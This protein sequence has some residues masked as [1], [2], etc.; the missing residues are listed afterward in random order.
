MLMTVLK[1]ELATK[2]SKALIRLFKRL[3]DHVIE[4]QGLIGRREFLLL[5]MQVSRDEREID[6]LRTRLWEVEDDMSRV[7]EQL[8]DLVTKSEMAPVAIDFGNP[9]IRRDYLVMN[10]DPV[11]GAL[12]YGDIYGWAAESIIVVDN[13]IGLKTLVL[14]KSAQPGVSITVISDNMGR[15][16]HRIEYEDFKR[17]YPDIDVEFRQTQGIV[18]DRYIALDY[19]TD[20]ERVFHCG[21]SSKDAGKKATT[22][23]EAEKPSIYHPLFDQLLAN[24]RLVLE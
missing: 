7:V 20:F 1:G 8:G 19:G 23:M 18:H 5:S 10:G 9:V 3:K 4:N 11:M 13:Y 15:K 2:Q 14:L 24:P 6:D 21:A 22:I 16:L 12:T 17:Q